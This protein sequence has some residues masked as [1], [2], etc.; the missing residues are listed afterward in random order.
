MDEGPTRS[1]DFIEFG[2]RKISEQYPV[3]DVS[4]AVAEVVQAKFGVTDAKDTKP[5]IATL[6]YLCV[7]VCWGMIATIILVF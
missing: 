3:I 7:S 6:L 1:W 5:I 2:P 4:D